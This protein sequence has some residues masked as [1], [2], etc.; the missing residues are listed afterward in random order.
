MRISECRLRRLRHDTKL[1]C[2]KKARE[3]PDAV[4]SARVDLETAVMRSS[5]HV[6]VCH[7]NHA[8]SAFFRNTI[9]CSRTSTHFSQYDVATAA[10]ASGSE[11]D[12]YFMAAADRFATLPLHKPHQLR[13]PGQR[14]RH[15]PAALFASRHRS[16]CWYG[17]VLADRGIHPT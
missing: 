14:S 4:Q 8:R 1:L 2:M 12:Q 9:L 13:K 3:E 17:D 6:D 16:T 5:E 15:I 7:F 11:S 10:D